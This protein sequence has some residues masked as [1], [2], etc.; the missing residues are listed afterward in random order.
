MHAG[1]SFAQLSMGSPSP[2]LLLDS[3]SAAFHN[4]DFSHLQGPQDCAVMHAYS[5]DILLEHSTFHRTPTPYHEHQICLADASSEVYGSAALKTVDALDAEGAAAAP[6]AGFEAFD[7][8]DHSHSEGEVW[9]ADLESGESSSPLRMH[10]VE[11]ESPQFLAADAG[12]MKL[13][14]V[15]VWLLSLKCFACLLFCTGIAVA[16]ADVATPVSRLPRPLLHHY[17]QCNL[18]CIHTPMANTVSFTTGK[19]K[20]N[21][22]QVKPCFEHDQDSTGVLS[23]ALCSTS[24]WTHPLRFDDLCFGLKLCYLCTPGHCSW[25]LR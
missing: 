24:I 14:R 10:D 1:C 7:T 11:A 19:K 3:G 2:A 15:C 16:V 9:V 4:C 13:V 23:N 17:Q 8:S 25:C 21:V 18:Q 22:M 5:G 20:T 6:Q 12:F